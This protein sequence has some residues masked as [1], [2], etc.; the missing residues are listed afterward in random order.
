MNQ[1]HSDVLTLMMG[2]IT[3]LPIQIEFTHVNSHLDAHIPYSQLP[4]ENQQNTDV[5]RLAQRALDDAV[6]S[7]NF[8]DTSFPFQ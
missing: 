4:F 1:S 8:I 7:Q 2:L 5:D 6:V 3:E